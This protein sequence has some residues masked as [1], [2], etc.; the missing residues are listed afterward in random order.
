MKNARYRLCRKFIPEYQL[1]L[2]HHDDVTC[3]LN[4]VS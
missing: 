2:R 3:T 1:W 4:T